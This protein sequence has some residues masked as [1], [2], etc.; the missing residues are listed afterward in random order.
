MRKRPCRVFQSLPS[1]PPWRWAAYRSQPTPRRAEA[2]VVA[3]TV[4]VVAAGWAVVVATGAVAE[5]VWAAPA[6]EE[7]VARWRWPLRRRWRPLRRQRRPLRA[8]STAVLGTAA[9]GSGS[10]S[11]DSGRIMPT[12]TTTAAAGACAT[13]A[14]RMG[15]A[16]H[17]INV[18][19]YRL[20][21]PRPLRLAER[22]PAR[23]WQ[24][25][26][27]HV[28]THRLT[29]RIRAGATQLRRIRPE[30]AGFPPRRRVGYVLAR[31]L[32]ARDA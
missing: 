22:P 20:L 13:C 10:D 18:C 7:A 24:G 9:S 27:R 8:A 4:V 6:L 16:W 32:R 23:H 3:A 26:L 14:R 31:D 19:D 21:R 17:R 30:N 1:R 28:D 25:D 5:C 2:E 12:R 11:A 15:W 29:G